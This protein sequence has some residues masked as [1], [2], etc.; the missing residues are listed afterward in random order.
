MTQ[1]AQTFLQKKNIVSLLQL[2]EQ[3]PG[4]GTKSTGPHTVKMIRDEVGKNK[5]YISGDMVD[6]LWFFVE[7][8]GQPFRYF[9]PYL[10]KQD[11]PHYLMERLAPIKEGDVVVLEYI[12]QGARGYIDVRSVDQESPPPSV[13]QEST[14]PQENAGYPSKISQ[15]EIPVIESDEKIPEPRGVGIGALPPDKPTEDVNAELDQ[16]VHE[17]RNQGQGIDPSIME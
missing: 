15:E 3:L 9:V 1:N 5:D 2:A 10:N 16:V 14:P 11:E 17:R 13:A 6:G 8:N 4:G 12:R 7:E